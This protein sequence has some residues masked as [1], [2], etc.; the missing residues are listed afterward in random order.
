MSYAGPKD[1]AQLTPEDLEALDEASFTEFLEWDCR[2]TGNGG[3]YHLGEYS[4]PQVFSHLRFLKCYCIRLRDRLEQSKR[5]KNL[6]ELERECMRLT[7]K[8][9]NQGVSLQ[10]MEYLRHQNARL[11]SENAKLR[12]WV[13]LYRKSQKTEEE[14]REQS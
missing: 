8:L 12:R 7:V 3:A 6:R 13:V 4:I 1:T 9:S 2:R 10:R 5:A 14:N 11:R